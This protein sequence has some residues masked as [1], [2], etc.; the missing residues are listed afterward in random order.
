MMNTIKT[1]FLMALIFALFIFV[2]NQIH[3]YG[4]YIA[5][6]IALVMNVG[7]YWLSDKIVLGVYRARIVDEHEAPQLYNIVERITHRAGLPMPKLAIVPQQ[8]PNAFNPKHSVVAVTE[9]ALKLLN[10]EELEGV[11]AHEVAH[12]ADRDMLISTI[13]AVM[14]GAIMI[15]ATM[16]RFMAFFGGFGGGYGGRGNRG[17]GNLIAL[18]AIAIFA[19]IAALLIRMAVSRTREYEADAQGA[20]FAGSP[21]GLAR[22][23]EK[24]HNRSQQVPMKTPE[25]TAHLFIVN[26]LPAQSARGQGSGMMSLFSTHPPVEERVRRLRNMQV[27]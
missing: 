20:R 14:A 7:T 13:V 11:L 16:T 19:P 18:L 17:G 1:S 10:E 23:L 5:G 15:I 12:I 21:E 9:G 27:M 24:L 26:P 6:A 2:G 22:A 4:A 3:P 25:V 8:A